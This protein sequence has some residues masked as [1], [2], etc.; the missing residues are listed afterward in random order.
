LAFVAI[1]L[2]YI[3][4]HCVSTSSSKARMP[5]RIICHAFVCP[6]HLTTKSSPS[7]D[8]M[9]PGGKGGGVG[10]MTQCSRETG[11]GNTGYKIYLYRFYT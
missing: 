2:K 5:E 9:E 10:G 3:Y 4:D 1:K 7:D 6:C 11:T 8:R